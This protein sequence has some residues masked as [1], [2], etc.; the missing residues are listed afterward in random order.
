[1]ERKRSEGLSYRN[2]AWYLMSFSKHLGD[3]SLEKVTA[4]EILA[5]LDAPKTCPNTWMAKYRLLRAFFS[6]WLARG[7]I[8]A[9]PMPVRRKT[10]Q[11]PFVPYIYTRSEIRTLLK[12]VH[13]CQKP[14][15][16]SI[17]AITVRAMLLFIYGTGAL[18]G[19]A[20]RLLIDDVDLK[21]GFVTIRRNRYDRSRT[22]PIG[23]HLQKALKDYF[24]ARP[25]M[26]AWEPNFFLNKHGSA[27]SKANLERTFERLRRFSGTCRRDGASCQPRM[28]DLRHTFAVHRIAGWIKHGADLNRM[29]PA[30]SV[31]M[32]LAGLRTTERYL[33]LTPERFRA[34]LCQLSPI[35]GKR[36]WR[37][38]PE[39]MHFLSQLSGTSPKL[40]G[41]KHP[42]DAHLHRVSVT[43]GRRRSD[44]RTGL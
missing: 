17:D 40:T 1:M 15:R 33:T 3:V 24:L 16:C 36:R 4:R 7:A 41:L 8:G 21:K 6:F 2:T 44:F 9:L 5:F 23:P 10:E 42:A 32:G 28:Y 34:Q 19:E 12:A 11:R 26:D 14:A 38:D 22:I 18:P 25:R 13:R 35:C 39:L 20:L 43:A 31:Y 37:D 29:L 27:I 30:L